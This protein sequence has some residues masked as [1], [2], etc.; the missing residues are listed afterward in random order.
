MRKASV[1]DQLLWYTRELTEVK[2]PINTLSL[3]S[4]AKNFYL[5]GPQ[6]TYFEENFALVRD[7]IVDCVHIIGMRRTFLIVSWPIW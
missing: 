3:K 1:N 6:R 2:N 5:I 7:L 4:L